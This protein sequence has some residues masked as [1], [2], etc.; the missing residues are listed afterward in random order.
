[1]LPIMDCVLPNS[2]QAPSNLRAAALQGADEGGHARPPGRSR[3]GRRRRR[4]RRHAS[5]ERRRCYL[6]PCSFAGLRRTR[7]L[8]LRCI[9]KKT[10]F[11]A[12]LH[13]THLHVSRRA[14]QPSAAAPMATN[15]THKSPRGCPV[16]IK[17]G[18]CNVQAMCARRTVVRRRAPPAAR[19]SGGLPPRSASSAPPA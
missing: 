6:L 16:S 11:R 10:P 7:P 5:H 2:A 17:R 18:I 15:P 13:S 14:E 9:L 12:T 19:A 8:L 3:C 4:R 1:M